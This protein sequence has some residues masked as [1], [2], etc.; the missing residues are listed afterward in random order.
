MDPDTGQAPWTH[1]LIP[2]IS[3]NL[4]CIAGMNILGSR[5]NFCIGSIGCRVQDMVVGKAS[6]SLWGKSY[7]SREVQ[8]EASEIVLSLLPLPDEN[9]KIGVVSQG[10]GRD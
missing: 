9:I 4:K 5:Q 2:D 3:P 1:G 10:D 8:V 7:P 6:E